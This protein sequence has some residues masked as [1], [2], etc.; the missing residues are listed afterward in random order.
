MPHKVKQHQKS[1]GSIPAHHNVVWTW[2]VVLLREYVLQAWTTEVRTRG[3]LVILAGHPFLPRWWLRILWQG[4]TEHNHGCLTF[5]RFYSYIFIH[6]RK[7]YVIQKSEGEITVIIGDIQISVWRQS[8]VLN[9]WSETPS[10]LL[11]SGW[12]EVSSPVFLFQ[13]QEVL[14]SGCCYTA[15]MS[16]TILS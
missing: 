3:T 5:N 10:C 8:L 4:A 11:G 6:V 12:L 15:P 16:L 1:K 7:W 13:S 2:N 9:I 14:Q